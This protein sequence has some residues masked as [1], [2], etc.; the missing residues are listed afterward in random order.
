MSSFLRFDRLIFLL[1][2]SHPHS[3]RNHSLFRRNPTTPI[4]AA[5][6]AAAVVVVVESEVRIQLDSI[7]YRVVM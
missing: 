4:F 2:L 7:L 5:V 1:L 3:G 6:V